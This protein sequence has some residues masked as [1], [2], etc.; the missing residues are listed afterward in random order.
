MFIRNYIYIVT[1][2]TH[3]YTLWREG[4]RERE[5]ERGI[6][7]ENREG[8]FIR[9]YRRKR[10]N[11]RISCRKNRESPNGDNMKA[12]QEIG[13]LCDGNFIDHIL[14]FFFFSLF[15]F[16]FVAAEG[17][18]LFSTVEFNIGN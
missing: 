18:S 14:F 10:D 17:Q 2:D 8:C 15:P 4:E 9:F 16:F 13:K 5:K 11:D 6:R 3:F 1:T 7:S 12:I